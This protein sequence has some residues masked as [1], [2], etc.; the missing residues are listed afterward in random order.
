MPSWTG[1]E[2]R[3][4]VRCGGR[5]ENIVGSGLSLPSFVV[6]GDKRRGDGD[7]GRRE[8]GTRRRKASFATVHSMC[9]SHDGGRLWAYPMSARGSTT[10]DGMTWSLQSEVPKLFCCVDEFGEIEVVLHSSLGLQLYQ[11][12]L[13]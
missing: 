2:Q 6:L 9:A 10:R 11:V 12:Q 7:W 5:Y 13:I 4:H 8:D 1:R 3:V